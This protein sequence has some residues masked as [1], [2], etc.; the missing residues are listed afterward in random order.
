MRDRTIRPVKYPVNIIL[1][2]LNVIFPGYG[3]ILNAFIGGPFDTTIFNMGL[4][5]V[6][7]KIYFNLWIIGVYWGLGIYEKKVERENQT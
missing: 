6:I 3:T 2:A 7:L 1:L 5:Q 4:L